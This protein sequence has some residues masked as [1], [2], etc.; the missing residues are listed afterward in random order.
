[1]WKILKEYGIE[2]D[3]LEVIK[4][5]YRDTRAT[6]R[7]GK[8]RS[9]DISLGTGVK[10]GCIL[11]PILFNIFIDFVVRKALRAA[12]DKGVR[13]RVG[14]EGCWRDSA[15]PKTANQSTRDLTI[16]CMLF[17]DDMNL[18]ADNYGDLKQLV[19]TIEQVS[20]SYGMTISIPKTKIMVFCPPEGEGR[21]PIVIR[22]ESIGEVAE[23]KYLGS[24][25]T[26]EGSCKV[27]IAKKITNGWHAFKKVKKSV[28]RERAF[29]DRTKVRV[30]K[31]QVLPAMLYGS[32]CWAVSEQAL[33]K[34]ESEQMRM[35]VV[36]SAF[37]KLIMSRTRC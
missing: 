18:L 19:D 11:S 3:T 14:E 21:E 6:I 7:I 2:G 20:Q 30:F 23:F 13:L 31:V 35:S 8:D 36:C 22:G 4:L 28:F 9:R 27:D 37:A 16:S 5:L 1:M 29:S 12:G 32:A 24:L 34:L 26:P 17:A 25:I 15:E 10:P 33:H